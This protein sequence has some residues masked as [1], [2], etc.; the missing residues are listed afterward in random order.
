MKRTL[1]VKDLG[2]QPYLPVLRE[3]ERLVEQRKA[4][5]VPDILLLVEHEHVYTLGRNARP[6]HILLSREQLTK[7]GIDVVET[8][9]GGDVTYHGPGQLVGYPLIDLNSFGKGVLWYVESLEQVL[10]R[11]VADFGIEATTDPN[12]RGVWVGENK[13]AAIG[14]RIT[15]GTTMHGF[16]LNVDP[17]LSFFDAIVPCGIR[18]RGVTSLARLGITA[19]LVEVKTRLVERFCEHFDYTL[20]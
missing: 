2:R 13:L 16:A 4:N 3:Q 8:G 1:L 11:T 12:Y 18:D 7:K 19:T 10:V 17:D 5:A 14:V 9:R 15:G 6:E 20:I